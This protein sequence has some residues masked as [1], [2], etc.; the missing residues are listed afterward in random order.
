M[1]PT[2]LC[3]LLLCYRRAGG[4]G[5]CLESQMLIVLRTGWSMI[6][7]MCLSPGTTAGADSMGLVLPSAPDSG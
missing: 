3:N 1:W 6:L 5:V 7:C 2:V 4:N